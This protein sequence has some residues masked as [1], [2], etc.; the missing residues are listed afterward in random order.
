MNRLLFKK[1]CAILDRY[2]FRGKEVETAIEDIKSHIALVFDK[3][4]RA[5]K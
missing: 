4:L 5:N 2:K 3:E 1:I